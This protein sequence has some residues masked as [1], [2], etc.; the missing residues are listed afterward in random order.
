MLL[1]SD[2]NE[3][4]LLVKL[5]NRASGR[6]GGKGDTAGD[7]SEWQTKVIG[8]QSGTDM[9]PDIGRKLANEI[10]GTIARSEMYYSVSTRP[11][12]NKLIYMITP[13]LGAWLF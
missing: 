2:Q 12:G 7:D 13:R 4:R 6:S 5:C 10:G 11:A 1:D 9:D 3:A 8:G